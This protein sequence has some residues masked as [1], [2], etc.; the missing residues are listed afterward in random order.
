MAQDIRRHLHRFIGDDERLAAD[1]KDFFNREWRRIFRCANQGGIVNSEHARR[2]FLAEPVGLGKGGVGGQR[3]HGIPSIRHVRLKISPIAD[4]T[5]GFRIAHGDPAHGNAGMNNC[6][7]MQN[8]RFAR[9]NASLGN[10]GFDGKS[11]AGF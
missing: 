1:L 7:M 6:R 5:L 11:E 10:G 2:A 3:L 8:H 9:H 4:F